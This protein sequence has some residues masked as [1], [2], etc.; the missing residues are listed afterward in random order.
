MVAVGLLL[1]TQV[2]MVGAGV[3]S[4]SFI[5]SHLATSSVSLSARVEEQESR[6]SLLP[7]VLVDLLEVTRRL[8][9]PGVAVAVAARP[10]S[11][12]ALMFRLLPAAAAAEVRRPPR[13]VKQVAME[14]TSALAACT[15]PVR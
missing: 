6:M 1:P 8:L 3:W 14:E 4:Q 10:L 12:Q 2:V 11:C 7:E 13:Q 9:T 15:A 5:R